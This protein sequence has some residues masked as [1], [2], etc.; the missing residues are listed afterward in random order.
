MVALSATASAHC[1][2]Q[3]A[4]LIQ[5]SRRHLSLSPRGPLNELRSIR[6]FRSK[7]QR[8]CGGPLRQWTLESTTKPLSTAERPLLAWKWRAKFLCAKIGSACWKWRSDCLHSRKTLRPIDRHR[9]RAGVG[10]PAHRHARRGGR[11]RGRDVRYRRKRTRSGSSRGFPGV[12]PMSS[13]A[14]GE[15]SEAAFKG[16]TQSLPRPPAVKLPGVWRCSAA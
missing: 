16:V 2:P 6:G 15:V 5:P 10:G 12:T 13:F 4:L 7:L 11:H 8:G 3:T 1:R 9:R 14:T